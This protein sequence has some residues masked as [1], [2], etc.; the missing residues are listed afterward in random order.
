MVNYLKSQMR[1]PI[2]A[3]FLLVPLLCLPQNQKMGPNEIASAFQARY[4]NSDY[5][6]VHDMFDAVLKSLLSAEQ[7]ADFLKEVKSNFGSIQKMDYSGRE[8]SANIYRTTFDS[9]VADI[10]IALNNENQ[11]SALFIPRNDLE[12][13]SILKRNATKMIFPFKE[14][15]FVYWGGEHIESNYHMED[16][17]QQFAYDILMVANG[18]PYEGDPAKN[19]SYFV[20][21]QEIMAPCDAKVVRVTDGIQDNIPGEVNTVDFTGNSIILE[22]PR[23]EYLLFAHL[24]SNSIQVREGD[25]VKQG[26][27]MAQCGN[28]GNTTQAHLHLQLQNTMDLFNTIGAR[29]YFDEILVNGEAKRD[30]MPKK[31]DFVKNSRN[32]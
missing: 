5:G 26:Q 29:L 10:S 32:P 21:G 7:T 2:I 27:V 9:A 20:F 16:M 8:N 18:A 25:L 3:L 28:S 30:Y 13:S 4:N 17:N 23:K 31:E 14:E 15:A 22:T 11:I 12:N 19:E 24:R 6:A 1:S